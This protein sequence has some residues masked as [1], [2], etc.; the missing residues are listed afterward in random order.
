MQFVATYLLSCRTCLYCLVGIV[1]PTYGNLSLQPVSFL[2]S[3][4]HVRSLSDSLSQLIAGSKLIVKQGLNIEIGNLRTKVK[5][6]VV[7]T[8][9]ILG[10]GS[11]GT[12]AT[13]LEPTSHVLQQS[14]RRRGRAGKTRLLERVTHC[15]L[16]LSVSPKWMS[17][18]QWMHLPV[19]MISAVRFN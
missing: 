18:N 11:T 5:I 15:S 1:C 4:Y 7:G 19:P 12:C 2:M 13:H 3:S 8:S 6:V 14:S 16:R 10:I 17:R 9:N